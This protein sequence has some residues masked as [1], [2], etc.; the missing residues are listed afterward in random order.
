[1]GK[2]SRVHRNERGCLPGAAKKSGEGGLGGSWSSPCFRV[3][4][5]CLFQLKKQTA[6]IWGF[7]HGKA[8]DRGAVYVKNLVLLFIEIKWPE[9]EGKGN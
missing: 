7:E 4:P 3:L 5:L 9:L 6:A 2:I 1:M 8:E